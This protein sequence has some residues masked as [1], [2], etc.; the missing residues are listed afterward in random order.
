MK[1]KELRSFL[2]KKFNDDQYISLTI[3]Y[4]TG[5]VIII[6]DNESSKINHKFKLKDNTSKF[7]RHIENDQECE[8][9]SI[10]IEQPAN[11]VEYSENEISMFF[12]RR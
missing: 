6:K 11:I 9:P 3:D 12:G 1:W 7:D 4:N 10:F 5:D 2:N 8:T